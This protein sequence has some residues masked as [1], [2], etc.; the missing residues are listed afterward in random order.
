MLRFQTYLPWGMMLCALVLVGC[1]FNANSSMVPV[2][3]KIL[4]DGVPLQ[5]AEVHFFTDEQSSSAKTDE[6]G[7]YELVTGT[8]PGLN[9][10]YVT[11]WEGDLSL[12][13]PTEGLDAGQMA[14]AAAVRPVGRRA[15]TNS[16]TPKQVLPAKYSDPV[17]TEL[18]VSV[19]ESGL[20]GADL[21]LTSK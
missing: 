4:V 21:Q 17:K 5:N 12:F 6:E 20:E 3:G 11:K 10:V 14:A 16:K 2:S 1:G 18:R 8:L 15:R 7:N 9:K 19:P 13:D